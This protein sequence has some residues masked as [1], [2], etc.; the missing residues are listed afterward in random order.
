M[1]RSLRRTLALAYSFGIVAGLVVLSAG[2]MLIQ[3]VLLLV[4]ILLI[5]LFF[6]HLTYQIDQIQTG[7]IKCEKM[8][9]YHNHDLLKQL[10]NRY[11]ETSRH[12][13]A[14]TESLSKR[15]YR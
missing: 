5:T 6:I 7:I 9:N 15:I 11:D 2:F 8:M 4:M 10:T 1:I 14:L 12:I 3:T 13:E